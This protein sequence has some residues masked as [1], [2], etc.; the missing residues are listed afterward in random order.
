MT[1]SPLVTEGFVFLDGDAQGVREQTREGARVHQAGLV[2]DPGAAIGIEDATIA[3]IIRQ[4]VGD[5]VGEDVESGG[6]NDFIGGEIVA[7]AD[8][9]DIDTMPEE[10][11]IN[12]VHGGMVGVAGIAGLDAG[13]PDAVVIVDDGDLGFDGGGFEECRNFAQVGGGLGEFLITAQTFAIVTEDSVP[14]LLPAG[15]AGAPAE[16]EDVIGSVGDLLKGDLT[17][18]A[19][20]R[21]APVGAPTARTGSLLHD[22]EILLLE[23]AHDVGSFGS[24]VGDIGLAPDGVIVPGDEIEVFSQ[25]VVIELVEET[26]EIVGDEVVGAFGTQDAHL[27]ALESV[28]EPRIETL[29]VEAG[30]GV[31]RLG[32]DR[33]GDLGPMGVDM[34]PKVR[35]P[36]F[37]ETIERGVS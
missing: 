2:L 26:H 16:P 4:P 1:T 21:V 17:H 14:V 10:G 25:V 31:M 23:A 28:I 20:A 33:N 18:L 11:L 6:E 24:G 34:T 19:G 29:P 5:R 37:V 22:P 13:R 27:V 15:G 30:G 7:G 36:G 12:T 9:V 35:A 8:K 32:V 3:D